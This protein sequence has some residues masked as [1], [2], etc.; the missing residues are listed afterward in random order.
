MRTRG[1]SGLISLFA[2][3]LAVDVSAGFLTSS[4]RPAA[5]NE[6]P[7]CLSSR[8]T[9]FDENGAK[10]IVF[11]SV[12]PL[13]TDQS[14]ALDAALKAWSSISGSSIRLTYTGVGP[15]NADKL[16][17]AYAD[18]GIGCPYTGCPR[19]DQNEINSIKFDAAETFCDSNASA[20]TF[21]AEPGF[22]FTW[23]THSFCGETMWTF[24]GSRIKVKPNV[25]GRALAQLLAH[26]IGRALGF[27]TTTQAAILN[28]V[29][30]VNNPPY[31]SGSGPY[32]VTLQPYDIDA[33]TTI[34]P[35]WQVNAPQSACGDSLQ[36]VSIGNAEPGAVYTWN[37][38]G[39]ATITSDPT[40]ST[41]TIRMPHYQPLFCIIGP[42]P[43]PSISVS[44]TAS[45]S[46]GGTTYTAAGSATTY[47]TMNQ[48]TLIPVHANFSSAAATGSIQV[49][50]VPSCGQW[51]AQPSQGS[52]VTITSGATGSGQGTIQYSVAANPTFNAR[53]ET[54]SIADHPFVI[55][56]SANGSAVMVLS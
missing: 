38:S 6:Q 14:Y 13:T 8:R 34:Y 54:L 12:G 42:C 15:D 19:L 5:I 50:G 35:A 39:G 53:S 3:V 23:N 26:H 29:F 20:E 11:T 27:A 10:T 47:V 44:V 49:N 22:P 4:S 40:K 25:T 32:V 56:Q 41:I 1:S 51:T 37:V 24:T 21:I 2:C 17:T 28:P 7:L 36:T 52:F 48:A 46:C 55:T 18:T 30:D 16:H 33:A 45:K 31:V 9:D 43:Q